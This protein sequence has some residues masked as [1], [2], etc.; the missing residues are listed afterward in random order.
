M[1]LGQSI[2]LMVLAKHPAPGRAKT[3]LSPPLA[4]ADAARL[5]AASLADTLAVVGGTP[6]RERVLAFD[7][8]ADGWLP[9][10]WRLHRQCGGTLDRRL[11]DALGSVDGP[12]LLVGMDTPQL[13]PEQLSCFDPGRYDAALGLARDGGYWAIGLVDP[14]AAARALLGVPMSTGTTGQHQLDRFAAQGMSVQ[15]LD[16]L[17]DV[18]TI[19]TAR[20]VAAGAPGTELARVLRLVDTPPAAMVRPLA[21]VG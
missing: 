13:R 14:G 20:E 7:G 3:R 1:S 4:A 17:T 16:L 5:A 21:E 15:A 8:P 2:T 6:A 19:Q 12:V 10:R 18:D 11:A 9:D